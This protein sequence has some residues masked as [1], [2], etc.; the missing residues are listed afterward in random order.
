MIVTTITTINQLSA[1]NNCT[2][3]VLGVFRLVGVGSWSEGGGQCN[4]AKINKCLPFRW[5][6]GGIGSESRPLIC[7]WP[8]LKRQSRINFNFISPST[9][10]WLDDIVARSFD[11]AISTCNLRFNCKIQLVRNEVDALENI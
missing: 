2:A 3:A 6:W 9:G 8:H 11:M 10:N 5:H 1:Y 4:V 7:S